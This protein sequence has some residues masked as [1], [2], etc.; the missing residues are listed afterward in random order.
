MTPINA[1][2]VVT[3]ALIAKNQLILFV[4]AACANYGG[5][6][7]ELIALALRILGAPPVNCSSVPI[8]N[9][10]SPEDTLVEAAGVA[11]AQ[12]R[13]RFATFAIN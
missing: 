13:G 12:L 1:I 8:S 4:Q 11:G 2:W 10:F 3:W 7:D 5:G 9:D 6:A